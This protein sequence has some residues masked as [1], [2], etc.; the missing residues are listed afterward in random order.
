MPPMSIIAIEMPMSSRVLVRP[1]EKS[2]P[3]ASSTKAAQMDTPVVV[4]PLFSWL[5]ATT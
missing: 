1:C 5:K 4:T 3:L 2:N